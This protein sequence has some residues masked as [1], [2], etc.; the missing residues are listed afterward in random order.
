MSSPHSDRRAVRGPGARLRELMRNPAVFPL[1]GV[2]DGLSARIGADCGFPAL[3]ASGLGMS[4]ALGVRDCEEASWTEL[5]Q[6]VEHVTAAT[7]VPVLV[8]GDTGHGNFNTARRFACRAERARA[9]GICLE[10]KASPK[11][12]SF[13]GDAHALAPI[14]EMCGKIA[15]CRD[16][17]T[18]PD[19]VIVARVEALIAG[20][21]MDVALERA[22]AYKAAGADAIFI[23]SR[24]STVAEIA[25]FCADWD[26][27]LPL[28]VAPT[29]YHTTPMSQ[30]QSLGISGVI[31][32]NQALRAATAAMR[33]ACLVLRENGPTGLDDSISTLKEI[34]T[35]LEYEE[36]EREEQHYAEL[37]TK[38]NGYAEL[39]A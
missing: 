24:Q 39:G 8:D 2:H 20:A 6:V 38:L 29:T 27:R 35:L 18:D 33:R 7:D 32:A 9:A 17:V 26:D 3:W 28:I 10:D 11:M 19:F 14:A 25:K 16:A 4:T 23:H 36:L 12:N 1:L 13:I 37:L 34:F 22:T 31:W 15:A 5:I 30:F 21:G